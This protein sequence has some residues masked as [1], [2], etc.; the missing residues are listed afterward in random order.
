MVGGVGNE[1]SPFTGNPSA[2]VAKK[3]K[4]NVVPCPC[5]HVFC[6]PRVLRAKGK[7]ALIR[8]HKMAPLSWKNRH[9]GLLVPWNQQRRELLCWVGVVDPDSQLRLWIYGADYNGSVEETV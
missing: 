4:K 6:C 9:F 5:G 8:R 1:R 2:S 3:K 7:N